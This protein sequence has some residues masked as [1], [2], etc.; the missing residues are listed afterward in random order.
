M[1]DY[2]I[3]NIIFVLFPLLLYLIY[4][5]YLYALEK[6]DNKLSFNL[7][8]I[9]S[10]YL[11]L[12]FSPIPNAV[13]MLLLILINKDDNL[14]FL[15]LSIFISLY[16]ND[17]IL[18]FFYLI[19]YIICFIIL[20]D[21]TNRIKEIIY[22]SFTLIFILIR[23][24][25]INNYFYNILYLITSFIIVL[26]LS[27]LEGIADLYG[28][29]KNIVYEK[30]FKNSIFEISHEIKNP[31]AVCKGYLD[32]LD[33][34]DNKKVNKYIPIVKEE[35]NR[36]LVMLNDYMKLDNIS[37][38]KDI[39]DVSILINN[40][41]C[42]TEP[43]LY[44]KNIKVKYDISDE[45][46]LIDGDYDRLKQVLINIIK[47]SCEAVENRGVI[48]IKSYLKKSKVVIEIKDNGCGISLD[49]LN[50]LGNVLV[51]TK[52]NRN[53]L[54]IKLSYDIIK[55]HNGC[56]RYKSKVGVGTLVIIELP[57]I[58]EKI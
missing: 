2:I 50:K 29:M 48:S 22:L 6:K 37:V 15:I 13:K 41:K 31:I 52:E 54:G 56:I 42:C 9:S 55:L 30:E 43:L 11:I 58:K 53:G 16:F 17:Y 34:N 32:M 8:I 21:K 36:T 18:L 40:L 28:T 57:I 24:F 51:S 39:M 46:L 14:F 5:M 7:S 35:I 20:K 25:Y 4:I 27:K 47:N 12:K 38:N 49:V 33:L 45:D 1:F 3:L 19:I 10:I 23:S 44:S 26:I